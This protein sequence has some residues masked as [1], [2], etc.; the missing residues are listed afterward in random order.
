MR[1][2]LTSLLPYSFGEEGM[3]LTALTERAN[4][5]VGAVCIGPV[6]SED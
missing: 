2:R 1:G 3:W 6:N 5:E 4:A